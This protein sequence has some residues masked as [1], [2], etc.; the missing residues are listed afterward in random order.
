ML[1]KKLSLF[2]YSVGKTFPLP[3]PAFEV[4]FCVLNQILLYIVYLTANL[5]PWAAAGGVTVSA[6]SLATP[7]LEDKKCVHQWPIQVRE[8]G[9]LPPPLLRNAYLSKNNAI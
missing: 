9:G 7:S 5:I 6:R 1:I 4:G 3:R 2:A 8:P